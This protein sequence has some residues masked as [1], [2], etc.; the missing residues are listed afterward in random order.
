METTKLKTITV[1]FCGP[2]ECVW[3]PGLDEVSHAVHFTVGAC[4]FVG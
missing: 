2:G 4:D 3:K 1:E